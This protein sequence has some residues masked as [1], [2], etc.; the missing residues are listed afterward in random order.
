MHGKK[1][2]SAYGIEVQ[3]I[4]TDFTAC[5]ISASLMNAV[6]FGL[7]YP[8]KR[9]QNFCILSLLYQRHWVCYFFI[10]KRFVAAY[11]TQFS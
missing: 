1:I 9:M 11:V 8:L 10:P 7:F 2:V 3:Q 4:L 5:R 6:K